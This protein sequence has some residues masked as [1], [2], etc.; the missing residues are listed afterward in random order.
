MMTMTKEGWCLKTHRGS[1]FNKRS[2]R[3]YFKLEGFNVAYFK[4]DTL[5]DRTGK[6]DLRKTE[7]RGAAAR[8]A[9]PVAVRG[10]DVDE[11]VRELLQQR[12]GGLHA[13]EAVHHLRLGVA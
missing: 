10:H 8:C 11:V 9:V 1:K 6:F 13:G 12:L 4:K 3:R 5:A 2:E 7:S